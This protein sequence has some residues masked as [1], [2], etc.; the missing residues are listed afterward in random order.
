MKSFIMC[1]LLALVCLL[2]V[3]SATASIMRRQTLLP[4]DIDENDEGIMIDDE[5]DI[6]VDIEMMMKRM[7]EKSIM[8]SDDGHVTDSMVIMKRTP[9]KKSMMNDDDQD[10][11]YNR[12]VMKRQ[13]RINEARILSDKA[14]FEM[15]VRIPENGIMNVDEA[16]ISMLGRIEE[17]SRNKMERQAK[18]RLGEHEVRDEVD[19][20]SKKIYWGGS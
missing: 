14:F 6:D 7:P 13:M 18:R 17:N 20:L 16:L 15:M 8:N 11:N 3:N 1:L 5:E 12:D 2:A 4:S 19:G 10:D 9:G